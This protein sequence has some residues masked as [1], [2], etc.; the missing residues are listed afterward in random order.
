MTAFNLVMTGENFPVSSVRVD[1][2]SFRHRP[3]KEMVRVPIAIQ[4]ENELAT[5]QILSE[6]FDVAVKK[7]DDLD[8]QSE[9]LVQLATTFFDYV[10]RRTITA[11]GH[12]AQWLLPGSESRKSEILRLLANQAPAETMLGTNPITADLAYSFKRGNE[13]IARVTVSTSNPGDVVLDFNFHFDLSAHGSAVEAVDQLRDSLRIVEEIGHNMEAL[14][15][16]SA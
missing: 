4:A 2:F 8:K 14:V 10:G 6:R 5:M 7:P 9:G 11:V 1:D 13:S 16:V 15:K 12:N 3:L